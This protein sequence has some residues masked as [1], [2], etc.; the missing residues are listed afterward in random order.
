MKEDTLL[1]RVQIAAVTAD[2]KQIKNEVVTNCFG[3]LLSILG[4]SYP[5]WD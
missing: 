2:I 3:S 1:F 4:N 5:K